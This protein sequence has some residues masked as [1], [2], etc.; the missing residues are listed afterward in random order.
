MLRTFFVTLGYIFA[1]E[2]ALSLM[3]DRVALQRRQKELLEWRLRFW[4]GVADG[5]ETLLL[6]GSNA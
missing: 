3:A 4:L 1:Q 2:T 5:I 6:E